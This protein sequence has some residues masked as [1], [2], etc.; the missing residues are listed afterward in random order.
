MFEA[1]R[2]VTEPCGC[3]YDISTGIRTKTCAE[4]DLVANL[5]ELC[6]RLR[7]E[8]A[9]ILLELANV[10][11]Q[12]CFAGEN[13]V[14]SS[15]C[16]STYASAIDLLEKYGLVEQIEPPFMRW[17][18]ARLSHDSIKKLEAEAWPEQQG[19]DVAQQA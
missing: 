2:L 9:A 14:L 19:G 5:N 8:R 17:R 15:N 10:V 6:A 16:I 11:G 13:G 12:A 18:K 1:D 3:R 4:H 7:R